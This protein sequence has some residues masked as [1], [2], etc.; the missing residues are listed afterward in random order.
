MRGKKNG[1]EKNDEGEKM[2]YFEKEKKRHTAPQQ[3]YFY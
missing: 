2:E 1:R 3:L